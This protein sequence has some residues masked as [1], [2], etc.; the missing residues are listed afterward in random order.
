VQF[1]HSRASLIGAILRTALPADLQADIWHL[2]F[3]RPPDLF[4]KEHQVKLEQL[5]QEFVGRSVQIQ[6]DDQPTTG[7]TTLQEYD[8]WKNR[9]LQKQRENQA[10]ED[11]QVK[12]ILQ[13]FASS[14]VY[15]IELH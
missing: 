14:E 3:R 2:Q 6:R 1:V 5:V 10:R 13:I 15:E 8:Q 7:G 9:E 12:D 11:D 4:S